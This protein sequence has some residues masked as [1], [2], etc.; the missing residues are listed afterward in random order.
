MS[1]Y[2][3]LIGAWWCLTTITGLVCSFMHNGTP[4]YLP[5]W[6]YAG[7]ASAIVPMLMFGV[8]YCIIKFEDR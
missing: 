1:R 6:L 2:L 8:V 4:F 7:I 3:Y 5:A